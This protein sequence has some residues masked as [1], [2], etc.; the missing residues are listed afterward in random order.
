MKRNT[1]L[2][3]AVLAIVT[4]LLACSCNKD[5][6]PEYPDDH[7]FITEG[8]YSTKEQR[9]M[10]EYNR[11]DIIGDGQL[12]GAGGTPRPHFASKIGG[13]PKSGTRLFRMLPTR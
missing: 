9:I 5:T 10:W 1:H 11:Q 13:L 3:A 6:T 12:C 7:Y 4:A 8:T 2:F